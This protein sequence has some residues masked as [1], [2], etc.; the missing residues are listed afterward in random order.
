MPK[1]RR[2]Q[3][4]VSY[5][6]NPH[7]RIMLIEDDPDDVYVFGRALDRVRVETDQEIAIEHALHGSTRPIASASMT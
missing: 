1:P 2:V 6:T 3:Q 7:V 5:P 4:C